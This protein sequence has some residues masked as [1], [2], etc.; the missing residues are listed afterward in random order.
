MLGYDLLLS[1]HLKEALELFRL[2][3]ELF[4]NIANCWDSYGEALLKGGHE[5]AALAAYEKALSINPNIPSSQKAVKMLT[6]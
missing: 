5:K 1:G 2:N 4:P 3:T 6:K